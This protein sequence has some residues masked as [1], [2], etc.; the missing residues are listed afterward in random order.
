LIHIRSVRYFKTY[1]EHEGQTLLLLIFELVYFFLSF[2]APPLI[3]AFMF[4]PGLLIVPGMLILMVLRGGDGGLLRLTVEGFFTSIILIVVL[5]SIMLIF[6]IPITPCSY[7]I[8]MLIIV[9]MLTVVGLVRK[10]RVKVNKDE[11]LLI[12]LAFPIYFILLLVFSGFP[13]F[14]SPD[15]THY[16]FSART[17]ILNGSPL[18]SIIPIKNEIVS[19]FIERYFWIYFIASFIGATG[20]PA[21]QAG[22]LGVCFLVM[23]ALTSSLIVSNLSTRKWLKIAVFTLIVTNPLLLSF[24][25]LA[26]NDLA[27]CFFSVFAVLHFIRSFSNVSF[28]IVDLLHSFLSFLIL[29]LVKLNITVFIAIWVIL[30]FII[31]KYRLYK[32]SRNYKVLLAT[33]LVPPVMYELFIDI[34]YVVSLWI[35]RN[36]GFASLLSRFIFISLA[37]RFAYWFSAPWWGPYVPTLLTRSFN[38]YLNCFYYILT[39]ESLSL[40]VPAVVLA[41]P[42]LLISRSI[43]RETGKVVLITLTCLSLLIF[44]PEAIRQLLLDDVCRYSLWIVP[45]GIILTLIVLDDIKQSSPFPNFLISISAFLLLWINVLLLREN[46]GVPAG[47]RLSSRLY[48]TDLVMVQFILLMVMLF[49]PFQEKPLFNI[50]LTI[51]RVVYLLRLRSIK[52]IMPY[53]AVALIVLNG[54]YFTPRFIGESIRY[55]DHGFIP[56]S[57]V[58]SNI[59]DN[60]S[61]VFANNYIFMRPY[62]GDAMVRQGLIL[63]PPDVEEE[64][65]KLL[66]AAPNGTVLLISSDS[67]IAWYE[68]AN[69]YIKQYAGLREVSSRDGGYAVQVCSLSLPWGKTSFFKVVN[70]KNSTGNAYVRDVAIIINENR[71]VTLRVNINTLTAGN[72]TFLLATDRSTRI[73]EVA[74][75]QDENDVVLYWPYIAPLRLIVLGDGY[76]LYNR[77]I[78]LQNVKMVN[79][80]ILTILLAILTLYLFLQFMSL[81]AGR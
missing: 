10:L 39:P 6:N 36:E 40:I 21:Y 4:L 72:Y 12:L 68:Y 80:A 17:C 32:S 81:K 16:I 70:S 37:E 27:V 11:F 1:I 42:I 9:L 43:S 59:L 5:T 64:L 78:T 3:M 56:L 73:Y 29:A 79:L 51:A 15:E 50:R 26:L 31:F 30:V 7:S 41:S 62:I 24:S 69:K 35:L 23:I 75:S 54:I 34:P 25:A 76:I 8:L 71:T 14:F 49:L 46:G 48:T 60:G 45:L 38:H 55:D 63:P 57:T 2:K 52:N 74:L 67:Y 77:I 33:I 19:V 13:R 28:K 66:N 44:Y 20:L 18:M 65:F 47:Y 22:L 61:L 53:I 58:I